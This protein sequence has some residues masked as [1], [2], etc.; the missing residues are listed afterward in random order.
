MA[1]DT[2][3]RSGGGESSSDTTAKKSAKKTTKKSS[4]ARKSSSSSSR[5]SSASAPRAEPGRRTSGSQVAEAA[6]RQLGELTSKEV[7]GVTGLHRD[8]DGW[9]VELEVLELRRIPTTTDVM[10]TYEVEMDASGELQGYHR[11]HRYVRGQA[12]DRA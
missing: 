4:S 6:V 5:R 8:D 9:R 11:V 3:K 1:E 12:E 7:E 10:A 2:N